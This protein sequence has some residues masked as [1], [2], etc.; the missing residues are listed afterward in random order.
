MT[1]LLKLVIAAIEALLLLLIL[2]LIRYPL[3]LL[4]LSTLDPPSHS[5]QINWRTSSL[6]LSSGLVMHSLP[7]LFLSCLDPRTRQELGT[8]L[9]IG[10]LFEISSLRLP[11]IDLFPKVSTPS[12][13]VSIPSPEV[14]TSIP[15]TKS[16]DYF[17]GSPFDESPHSSP[18]SLTPVP[19]E[20]PAPT[21]TLHR[22]SLVTSLH[23]HLRDFHCYTT[24]ASL[25]S[26]C[27]RSKLDLTDPLSDTKLVLLPKIYTGPLI[28][29]RLFQMDVKNVFLNGDLSEEVY[30]QPSS[31]SYD[32]ALFLHRTGKGTIL[33]LLYVDDMIITNDDLS[34]IQELKDFLSQNFE[35]K[36]LGHLS[37]FLG[38]EITSYDDGF[39]LTQAKYTFDLLSR[40]GLIDHKIVDTPIELNAPLTLS[41]REPLT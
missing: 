30:M 34:G 6:R 24:R 29:E 12:L 27:S 32:S 2:I 7:L 10:R 16:S 31:C 41:S 26:G 4:L 25:L 15:Q 8:S 17:S 3:L 14:S 22:S 11:T 9:K 39:Y 38:L 28:S 20:D 5:P 13:E 33:L 36:D 1:T 19:S 35:M 23:S 18:K 37:Y 40:A 21:T